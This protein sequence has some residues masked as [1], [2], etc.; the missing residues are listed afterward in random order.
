MPAT[1]EV[2][3]TRRTS[4]AAAASTAMRGDS[5]FIAPDVL[6]RVGADEAGAVEHRVAAAEGAPQGRSVEHVRPDRLGIHVAQ[7]CQAA[8]LPVCDSHGAASGRKL[9]HVRADEP[10]SAGYTDRHNFRVGNLFLRS[11]TRSPP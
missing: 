4:S 11:Y 6:G 7:A 9:C 2:T 3:T 5:A 1:L 10:G 8:L